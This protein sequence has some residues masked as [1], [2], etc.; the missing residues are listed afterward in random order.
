MCLLVVHA[1]FLIRCLVRL[2]QLARDLFFTWHQK[3]STGFQGGGATTHSHTSPGDGHE[4][5]R[6]LTKT[7]SLDLPT[8]LSL[9]PF[10]PKQKKEALSENPSGADIKQFVL[11]GLEDDQAKEGLKQGN[12]GQGRRAAQEERGEEVG[13]TVE[14]VDGTE[15]TAL[16]QTWCATSESYS[17]CLR[18][19]MS[20]LHQ[21]V[22][23][24]MKRSEACL[25]LLPVD[26]PRTYSR[27]PELSRSKEEEDDNTNE[28]ASS[29]CGGAEPHLC[30]ASIQKP[31]HMSDCLFAAP[32]QQSRRQKGEDTSQRSQ[33]RGAGKSEPSLRLV[34]SSSSLSSSSEP[35][36]TNPPDSLAAVLAQVCTFA[37][38][39]SRLDSFSASAADLG[40]VNLSGLRKF[41]NVNFRKF[42]SC[43]VPLYVVLFEGRAGGAG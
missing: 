30:H 4:R 15:K 18:L 37:A 26:E 41:I 13:I 1:G 24:V 12:L 6:H 33:G 3:L 19:L 39:H 17:A 35:S 42:M 22:L 14:C 40:D 34:A 36:G 7:H 27:D 11:K 23:G 5:G 32:Q 2:R 25:C 31:K 20:E 10:L 29:D 28:T 21:Q 8:S 38:K 43:V 9:S 16:V